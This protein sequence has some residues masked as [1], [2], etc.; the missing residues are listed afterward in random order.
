LRSTSE[1]ETRSPASRS[2]GQH[3]LHVLRC[4]GIGI[5]GS[6]PQHAVVADELVG[7]VEPFPKLGQCLVTPQKPDAVDRQIAEVVIA[8]AARRASARTASECRST[9][10]PRRV[11]GEGNSP[12]PSG[13]R[14]VV[15]I[16]GP[17]PG[18]GR[19]DRTAANWIG[20]KVRS[21]PAQHQVRVD[22]DCPGLQLTS[23]SD[24]SSPRSLCSLRVA[25]SSGFRLASSKRPP[26]G[27]G[28]S[29]KRTFSDASRS[30]RRPSRQTEAD[31]DH[32][33][34]HPRRGSRNSWDDEPAV[35]SRREGARQ[36]GG[37]GKSERAS[38]R[39]EE[40]W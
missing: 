22:Q 13:S 11:R 33:S 38:S 15:P 5:A 12:R 21:A 34:H 25:D 29:R 26:V 6:G 14:R 9:L 32:H 16:P 7:I 20:S 24:V 1:R 30:R 27:L 35:E 36:R 39:S 19:I 37:N 40:S 8:C 17:G 3:L 28:R 23:S 2:R 31:H 4:R 18:R 10:K